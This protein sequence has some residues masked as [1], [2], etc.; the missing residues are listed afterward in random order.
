MID[1]VDAISELPGV[2]DVEVEVRD[3]L[4]E[5]LEVFE[6]DAELDV[7]RLEELAL[8]EVDIELGD[9]VP[10]L[11]DVIDIEVYWIEDECEELDEISSEELVELETD[12]CEELDEISSEELVELETDDFIVVV[13]QLSFRGPIL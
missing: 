2:N 3:G 11:L 4:F 12:D 7:K 6:V 1:A 9:G 5:V 10:E 13:F 8:S